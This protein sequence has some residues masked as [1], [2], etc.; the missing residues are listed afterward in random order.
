M[1]CMPA[2]KTKSPALT[3]RL[4]VP[5]AL[6]AP[7]GLSVLTPFGD[8]DC[9][10]PGLDAITNAATQESASRCNMR[11]PF[12]SNCLPDHPISD[13]SN[14]G[15]VH[16]RGSVRPVRSATTGSHDSLPKGRYPGPVNPARWRDIIAPGPLRPPLEKPCCR[17]QLIFNRP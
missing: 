7:G 16:A 17:P 10:T 5:S 12:F 9:A 1:P 11:Y 4:Q 8:G 13:G 15:A 3:P 14:N 6:M 2:T